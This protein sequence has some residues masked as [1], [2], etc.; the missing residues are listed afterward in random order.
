MG[1]RHLG[2]RTELVVYFSVGTV[3]Y[4]VKRKEVRRGVLGSEM[5]INVKLVAST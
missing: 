5:E 1:T 2:L 3:P 4:V